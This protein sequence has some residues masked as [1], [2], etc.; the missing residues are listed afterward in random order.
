M[1]NFKKGD[2][3]EWFEDRYSIIKQYGEIIQI[4]PKSAVIEDSDGIIVRVKLE[5]LNWQ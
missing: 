2:L 4:C 1:T 5:N 3:V